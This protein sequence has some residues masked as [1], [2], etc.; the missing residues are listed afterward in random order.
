M[1]T[2]HASA[3]KVAIIQVLFKILTDRKQKTSTN[4]SMV[5]GSYWNSFNG[6]TARRVAFK[7]HRNIISSRMVIRSAKILNGRDFVVPHE[8]L[9]ILYTKLYTR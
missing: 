4:E 8:T 9:I 6:N 2:F 3:K 1:E 7:V 5:P